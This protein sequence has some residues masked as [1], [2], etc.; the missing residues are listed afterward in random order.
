MYSC[1]AL[2]TAGTSASTLQRDRRSCTLI[3]SINCRGPALNSGRVESQRGGR[4]KCSS[5]RLLQNLHFASPVSEKLCSSKSR[6]DQDREW[7]CLPDTSEVI[8]EDLT[9]DPN[10]LIS[11]HVSLSGFCP[12]WEQISGGHK[13]PGDKITLILSVGTAVRGEH[14]PISSQVLWEPRW[15]EITFQWHQRPTSPRRNW[16]LWITHSSVKGHRGRVK[17]S[18][19]SHRSPFICFQPNALLLR[20][21]CL[22]V[23]HL[24][25][26]WRNAIFFQS[27]E[28]RGDYHGR[29]VAVEGGW[30]WGGGRGGGCGLRR[31]MIGCFQ[32]W[33]VWKTTEAAGTWSAMSSPEML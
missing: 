31:R 8:I 3:S 2:I 9:P 10:L 20:P 21:L 12:L 27:K 4:N 17:T 29:F 32:E 28:R 33:F 11:F 13:G 6:K 30:G 5:P 23:C 19:A 14:R 7:C 15:C 25:L 18:R 24:V 1:V 26:C 16:G 22:V